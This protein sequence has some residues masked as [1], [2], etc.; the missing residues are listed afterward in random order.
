MVQ[1]VQVL[2]HAYFPEWKSALKYTKLH[3]YNENKKNS[4]FEGRQL[5]LQIHFINNLLKI[6]S[7]QTN[8]TLYDN[9]F[10]VKKPA[11]RRSSQN[12]WFLILFY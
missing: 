4:K 2:S 1:L 3:F 7:E 5:E 9:L 10:W 6:C 8:R 12:T 11:C